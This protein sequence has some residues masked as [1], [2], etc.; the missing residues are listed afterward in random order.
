L[1]L[2]AIEFVLGRRL[3]WK[4]GR[5]LYLH[6]RREGDL[7]M[8]CNG[9]AW[10]AGAFARR[11]AAEQRSLRVIDVG[12][13]Y[14]QWSRRLL[15]ALRLE[16]APSADFTLFEPI[17]EIAKALGSIIQEYPEHSIRIEN[18]AVSDQPGT[19]RMVKTALEPGTGISNTFMH[20]RS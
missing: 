10:L 4:I 18:R 9:E 19:E 16:K 7:D 13:N 17:P 2:E 14:G 15:Q 1:I 8:D 5:R 11:S 6:A 12:A 20:P 3:V